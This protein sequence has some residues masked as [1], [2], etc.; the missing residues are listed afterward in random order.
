MSAGETQPP[1]AGPAFARDIWW[2][3]RPEKARLGMCSPDFT[4]GT[5]PSRAVGRDA[6]LGDRAPPWLR[7][8]KRMKPPVTRG[9]DVESCVRH[10]GR[11][12]RQKREFS[13]APG[14]AAEVAGGSW[15]RTESPSPPLSP[16]LR[17]LKPKTRH[18]S[19][20]SWGR[21]RITRIRTPVPIADGPTRGTRRLRPWQ[22]RYRWKPADLRIWL[23]RYGDQGRG[24]DDASPAR[25]PPVR[26]WFTS[27]RA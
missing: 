23:S 9:P 10:A 8:S 18:K 25:R 12:S 13:R 22:S 11:P 26:S 4:N 16:V 5:A 3:R 6:R 2:T 24:E 17:I 15:M 20:S 27:I 19:L 7:A 14:A 1:A 21:R